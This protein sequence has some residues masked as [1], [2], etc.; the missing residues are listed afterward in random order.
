MTKQ[1][2]DVYISDMFIM[3]Q[4][5][6][7]ILLSPVRMAEAAFVPRRHPVNRGI[8]LNTSDVAGANMSRLFAYP[9]HLFRGYLLPSAGT[10]LSCTAIRMAEPMSHPILDDAVTIMVQEKKLPKA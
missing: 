6:L 8:R 10:V 5:R 3:Y 2:I 1:A 9:S 7:R 4:L